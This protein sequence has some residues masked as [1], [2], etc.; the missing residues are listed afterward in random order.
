VKPGR[1]VDPHPGDPGGDRLPGVAGLGVVH[2]FRFRSGAVIG[3]LTTKPG[4][5]E[6]LVGPTWLLT[7]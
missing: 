7:D 4:P 5:R 6:P 1:L 3:G 2:E